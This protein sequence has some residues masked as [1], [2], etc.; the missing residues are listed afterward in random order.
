M[1]GEEGAGVGEAGDMRKTVYEAHTSTRR[2]GGGMSVDDNAKQAMTMCANSNSRSGETRQQGKSG[3][4]PK[5]VGANGTARVGTG[6]GA[7]RGAG[8]AEERG[9]D[10]VASV[11]GAR[12]EARRGREQGG[13]RARARR[14][15]SR[16]ARAAAAAAAAEATARV[17]ARRLGGRGV[18]QLGRVRGGKRGRRRRRR[19]RR[20][21][22]AAGAVCVCTDGSGARG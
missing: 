10:G 2:G 4:G 11:S 1:Y 13:A 20:R 17:R 19:R 5:E 3:R 14:G 6:G 8:A 9:N 21:G 15:R 7:Q 18:A 12:E 16:V 22:G